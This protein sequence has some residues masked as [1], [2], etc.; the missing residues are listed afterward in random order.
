MIIRGLS[1]VLRVAGALFFGFVGLR[2]AESLAVGDSGTAEVLYWTLI[3][4]GFLAF[5]AF[6]TPVVVLPAL[7]RV[8]E[9]A[10]GIRPSQLILGLIGL[11]SGLLVGALISPALF[12]LPGAGGAIAPFVVSFTLAVLGVAILVG[13]EEEFAGFIQRYF[14][15]AA[16][17]LHT[18]IVLD[19]SAIIDGRIADIAD[20][21][22]I[23]G[24]LVVPRFVLDELRHIADSP[25]A[26]RRNRGRRGLE[27]L[28]RLQKN[29]GAPVRIADEDYEDTMDVDAKLIRLCRQLNAPLLTNDFNL[30]RLAELDRVRV[31][32]VNRLANAVK[33]VILPGE[34][35]AVR[36]IQEGKETG[37]GVA[38]LDDGTMVVVEGGKRYLNEE[39]EVTVTRVLQTVAGRMIFAQPKGA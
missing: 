24:C 2:T 11:V 30:A 29:A 21:G 33:T 10:R 22:F 31:L 20:T 3:P 37:Q 6:V 26:V 13:R 8:Q 17:G 23:Q 28:S 19:T 12:T 25:E 1:I 14:P 27:V 7:S 18:E 32:N 39:L 38:F 16:T 36:I 35:M 9:W 5:G 15:G 34:E 4:I